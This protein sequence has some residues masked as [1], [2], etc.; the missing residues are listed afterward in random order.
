MEESLRESEKRT[1]LIVD[2][3][4]DAFIGMDADGLITD[5]NAQAE[6]TFGWSREEA[7]GKKVSETIIPLHHRNGHQKGLKHFL[8]TGEGTVFN[9]R[10]EISAL[11]RDGHEFPVELSIT[12]IRLKESY[13]FSAFVH[14]ITERKQATKALQESESKHRILFNNIADPIF[15]FDQKSNHFLDCNHAV[16]RIYGY[17]KDE[18]KAMTP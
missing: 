18:L 16:F 5:W 9:K 12:P 10:I 2:T 7:L 13:L 14:D 17:T 8:A 3:A 4:Y 11:H 6:T 15:I 1:R